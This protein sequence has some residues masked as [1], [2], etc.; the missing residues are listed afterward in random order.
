[1]DFCIFKTH[2]P[3]LSAAKSLSGY[4]EAEG[5]LDVSWLFYFSF[6]IYQPSL[7]RP[8]AND[9]GVLLQDDAHFP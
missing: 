7:H 5:Q 4:D 8:G 6:M 3:G 9:A 2:G 1:M